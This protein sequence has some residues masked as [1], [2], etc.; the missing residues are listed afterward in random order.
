VIAIGTSGILESSCAII[1]V[2]ASV[3]STVGDTVLTLA[4]GKS[5]GEHGLS[6]LTGE[7][8]QFIRVIDDASICM[9]SKEYVEYL[10]SL[11]CDV[12][13]WSIFNRVSCAEG[14]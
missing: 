13:V 2:W 12:Y 7:D 11:N 9:S 10:V 3:A 5:S 1:P 14:T 6:L 8:C 4:T